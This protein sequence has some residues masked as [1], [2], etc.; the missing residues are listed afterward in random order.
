MEE[1]ISDIED[2]NLEINQK[3]EERNLRMK[4]NERE[5]QEVADTIRREQ[6]RIMGIIKGE[7]KEHGLESI[8]R[9]IVDKNFQNLRNELELGI[10]EVNRTPNYLNPKKPSAK[11]IVLKL[12]KMNYKARIL[13]AARKK[14]NGD[15]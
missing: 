2:R 6:T 9:Q 4:N 12:S 11:H 5:I 3:K 13:R 7:E 1:K 14:N 8:F 10:Q 15:L